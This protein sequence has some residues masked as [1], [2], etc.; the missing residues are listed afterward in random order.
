MIGSSR[1]RNGDPVPGSDAL[2]RQSGQGDRQLNAL[3]D[4]S[5]GKGG[6]L[7]RALEV[8]SAGSEIGDL[9]ADFLENSNPPPS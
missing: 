3:G 4:S 7:A 5:N 6:D 9:V 8:R 1:H 2:E